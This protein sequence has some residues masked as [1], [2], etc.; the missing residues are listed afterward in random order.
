[1]KKHLDFGSLLVAFITL[2]LFLAAVFTQGLSH[3]LFLE[4]G[5]FLVSVKLIVMAY[6]TSVAIGN[7]SDRLDKILAE[8]ASR[9]KDS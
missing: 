5:I 2:A 8:L 4:A 3:N 1:M 6:K 9:R 7:L